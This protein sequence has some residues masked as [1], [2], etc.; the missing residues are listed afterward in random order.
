MT[1]LSPVLRT[2]LTFCSISWRYWQLQW[3]FTGSPDKTIKGSSLEV[4]ISSWHPY[5]SEELLY[6]DLFL[7]TTK[8]AGIFPMR[9]KCICQ[10]KCDQKKTLADL[11]SNGH[12]KACLHIIFFIKTETPCFPHQQALVLVP[13][14][15]PERILPKITSMTFFFRATFS[16][17]FIMK[18]KENMK[19]LSIQRRF[20]G[21]LLNIFKHETALQKAFHLYEIRTKSP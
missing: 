17:H 1:H 20:S 10:A 9:K 7:E 16:R 19:F 13:S 4:F 11:Y 18:W 6:Y 21:F 8:A 3:A 14:N 2:L 12:A 15:R 5:Y